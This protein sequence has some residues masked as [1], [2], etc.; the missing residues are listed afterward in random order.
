MPTHTDAPPSSNF[1]TQDTLVP[2]TSQNDDRIHHDSYGLPIPSAWSPIQIPAELPTLA[3]TSSRSAPA[4]T[5]S[6]SNRGQSANKAGPAPSFPQ[7]K[8][9]SLP[10]PQPTNTAYQ[11]P[12]MAARRPKDFMRPSRVDD[13]EP[14]RNTP[15]KPQ[16]LPAVLSPQTR[17]TIQKETVDDPEAEQRSP[18]ASHVLNRLR[19]FALEDE[20]DNVGQT[21][22]GYG[23]ERASSMDTDDAETKQNLSGRSKASTSLDTDPSEILERLQTQSSVRGSSLLAP[24]TPRRSLQSPNRAPVTPRH[25]GTASDSSSVES[26]PASGTKAS[27]IGRAHV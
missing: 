5:T 25:W 13:S 21:V 23:G 20:N 1:R 4:L 26:F 10:T 7:S 11:R 24:R 19:E 12:R 8:P 22:Y 6:P 27:E 14:V 17:K 16:R 15:W 2:S 18:V 9:I 3:D